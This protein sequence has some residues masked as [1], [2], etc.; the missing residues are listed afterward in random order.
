M[1]IVHTAP[2]PL[3]HNRAQAWRREDRG[4]YE[5]PRGG[6]LDRW[7]SS[8]RHPNIAASGLRDFEHL[9]SIRRPGRQLYFC[10]VC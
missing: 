8:S 10:S 9:A 6:R 7:L 1:G 3:F 2:I 5:W 4:I